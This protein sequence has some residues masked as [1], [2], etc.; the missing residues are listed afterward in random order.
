MGM[1]LLDGCSLGMLLMDWMDVFWACFGTIGVLWLVFP[2][3]EALTIPFLL[4]LNL[5]LD[6][7]ILLLYLAI[8]E[9]MFRFMLLGSMY[10]PSLM[11]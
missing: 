5:L 9:L 4:R 2:G 7:K 3:T 11:L 10:M 6:T 1:L 8:P